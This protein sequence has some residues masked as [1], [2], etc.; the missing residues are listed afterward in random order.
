M[1]RRE[2]L[3]HYIPGK[4]LQMVCKEMLEHYKPVRK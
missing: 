2:M 3:E 1:V 4:K